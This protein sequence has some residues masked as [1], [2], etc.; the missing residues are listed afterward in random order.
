[1][2][3]K[4]RSSKL[5]ME[6]DLQNADPYAAAPTKNHL[7]PF[8][9]ALGGGVD[10]NFQRVLD[11]VGVPSPFVGTKTELDPQ[12]LAPPTFPAY[13]GTGKELAMMSYLHPPFN[14]VPNYREPGRINI[15]TI[16]SDS[17][18]NSTSLVWNGVQNKASGDL[19]VRQWGDLFSSR[20][21]TVDLKLWNVTP[22][23]FSNPFRSSAGESLVMPG[24]QYL[25]DR[26]EIDVTLLRPQSPLSMTSEPLFD[27]KIADVDPLRNPATSH[28]R[29]AAAEQPGDHAQQRLC[30][31]DHGRVL[32]SA[33]AAICIGEYAR[34]ECR[35][36]TATSSCRRWAPTPARLSGI[37]RF[38]F[39]IARFRSAL[40]RARIITLPM[41]CC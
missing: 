26:E 32:R 20:Q 30:H 4:S 16:P 28:S 18:T 19:P 40:S 25:D 17:N 8:F 10:P 6:Y 5:L 34:P 23:R 33:D 7:L 37:G 9:Q 22:T 29:N 38:I 35:I 21:G 36:P 24:T 3:P 14:Q 11:Y 39:M 2:V 41:A 1:M 27:Y 12:T 15:N 31:L 13:D